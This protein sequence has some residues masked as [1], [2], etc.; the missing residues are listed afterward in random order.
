MQ[1]SK[2]G[3]TQMKTKS[4][5]CH[6]SPDN[7]LHFSRKQ[8]FKEKVCQN[9]WFQ[10]ENQW[11]GEWQEQWTQTQCGTFCSIS[12]ENMVHRHTNFAHL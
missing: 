2:H 4:K 3:K 9:V 5:K 12:A 1:A 6:W 10:N 7:T 11:S 8:M